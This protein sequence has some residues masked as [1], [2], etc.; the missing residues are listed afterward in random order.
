MRKDPE[1][2]QM[3]KE[4]RNKRLTAI[5]SICVSVAIVIASI[6][7]TIAYTMTNQLPQDEKQ[8]SEREREV[9]LKTFTPV[10]SGKKKPLKRV[11]DNT[12][13]LNLV[14]FYGDEPLVT[15][16]NSIPVV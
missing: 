1:K 2:R 3:G 12:H 4:K 9:L 8:L 7:G 10:S 14:N 15:L 16:W 13:P 6:A 5:V 11:I